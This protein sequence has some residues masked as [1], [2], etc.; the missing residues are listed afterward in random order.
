M[1]TMTAGETNM[2][3]AGAAQAQEQGKG[4]WQGISGSILKLLAVITMLLDHIGAVVVIRILTSRGLMDTIRSAD[5]EALGS[6]F[7]TLDNYQVYMIY[8]ALRAIGRIAFP[9]YCFMLV[10]G[11]QKTRNVWK[12]ALRLGIFALVSEIPFDLA[13]N[14]TILEFGYQNVFFTLFI[15]LLTMIALE[16]A[17]ERTWAA[18]NRRADLALKLLLA[19][20][21]SA[22]GMVCAA[23]LRPDYS[24]RGIAC[25]LVMY[26]L[27][28]RKWSQ[29]IAGY[30][31]FVLILG[32]ITAF[33][34]FLALAF[35]RGRKG[36]GL[37]YFFYGFYPVHLLVL[38]LVCILLG[39]AGYPAL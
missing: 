6:W 32:E 24:W 29:L 7:A 22:A 35:Y 2:R 14:G 30:I 5:P 31:A 9:I 15:G 33:P 36:I 4:N 20:V 19:G 39:I 11:L 10:E 23:L 34:A 18:D 28:K 1:E 13:F 38:Y 12:Y 16:K 37:K 27:R 21:I 25:I 8:T 26:F 17:T 3:A